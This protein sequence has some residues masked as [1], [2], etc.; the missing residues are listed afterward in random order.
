MPLVSVVVPAYNAEDTVEKTIQDILLQSFR[1]FEIILVD[2]GSKDNTPAICDKLATTDSRINVIHQQNGG[3]SNARNNGTRVASGEYVTYIDSDDRIEPVYLEYLVR[4][5][6]EESANIAC[7]RIDRVK[8][9]YEMTEETGEYSV[10]TFDTKDTLSEMLTGKKLTVGACCR[11]VPR[12]WQLQ[13]PFLD[14]TYYEDLSN[15][16]KINMLTKKT[17][18]VDSVLYHYVMRGGSI[19]GRKV[20]SV[21]QCI[22]YNNAINACH[23]TVLNTY[24]DLENDA[25]VLKARDYMSLYLSIQRCQEKNK[26]LLHMEETIKTWMKHNWA[27]AANNPKA[28][29][30]VRLRVLLFRASPALYE[31]IYYIGIKAKGKAI[32]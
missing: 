20:T 9:D 6:K 26:E 17:V 21:K 12:E 19:T 31:K 14:G 32:S 13:H 3:L 10:E 24:P 30:E 23:D 29:K 28:P 25:A 4:A 8:E 5:I 16:Y 27:K 15:T 22:D 2:D 7:G 11:L 18:F 1:G